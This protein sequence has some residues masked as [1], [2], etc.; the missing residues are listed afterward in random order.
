[1]TGDRRAER[2]DQPSAVADALRLLAE[3]DADRGAP[4]H[5][6]AAVQAAWRAR[7]GRR[8]AHDGWQADERLQGEPRPDERPLEERRNVVPA[9]AVRRWRP[10]LAAMAAAAAVAGMAIATL[11]VSI[12]R[13]SARAVDPAAAAP[14]SS[15]RSAQAAGANGGA[16]DRG[17]IGTSNSA[18]NSVPNSAPNSA[19]NDLA[20]SRVDVAARTVGARPADSARRATRGTHGTRGAQG[21]RGDSTGTNAGTGAGT[22]TAGDETAAIFVPLPYVEPLR[23]TEMRQ[24]V[25]VAVPHATV[26]LAGL[27]A[28]GPSDRFPSSVLADVLVG[29][30]GVARGIRLVRQNVR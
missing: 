19:P 7:H 20:K 24:V 23:P 15:I 29:E 13:R 26:M 28:Q 12:V 25:R 21:T 10:S 18:P 6:D 16:P 30:D 5:V 1:M 2:A 27:S 22:G 3:A 4:P 11:S 8:G 17:S 14:V 9:F